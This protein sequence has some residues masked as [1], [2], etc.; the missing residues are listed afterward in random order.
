MGRTLPGFENSREQNIQHA[1]DE[2]S[3][4][5]TL[6]IRILDYLFD[7]MLHLGFSLDPNAEI[8]DSKSECK[9]RCPFLTVLDN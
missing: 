2:E 6:Y 7:N 3:P 9:D 5:T 8:G 4:E 1:F